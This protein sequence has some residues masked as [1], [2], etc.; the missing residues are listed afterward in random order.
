[1]VGAKARS[2]GRAAGSA[3]L[4]QDQ[5]SGGLREAQTGRVT[6]LSWDGLDAKLETR[7]D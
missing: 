7:K 4:P 1:M 2:Q 3:S 6:S 5:E